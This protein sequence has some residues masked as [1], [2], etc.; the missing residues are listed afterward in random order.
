[1][2]IKN[3]VETLN[4]F[5]REFF[6]WINNDIK[7][8]MSARYELVGNVFAT[9]LHTNCSSAKTY[10]DFKTYVEV[11]LD[12]NNGVCIV[13]C[14]REYTSYMYIVNRGE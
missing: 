5:E 9:V 10:L 7:T 12:T 3:S 8:E 1:M 2:I 13:Y 11:A 14:E 6:E 4:V